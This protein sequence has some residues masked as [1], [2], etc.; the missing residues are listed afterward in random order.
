[1]LRLSRAS[2]LYID[3]DAIDI[4]ITNSTFKNNMLDFVKKLIVDQE[5]NVELSQLFPED[6]FES[7]T[8]PLINVQINS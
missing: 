3:N 5:Q 7:S 4:E 1:M 8:A 2:A 6:Y